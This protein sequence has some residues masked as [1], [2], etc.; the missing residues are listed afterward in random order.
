MNHIIIF[1]KN[2]INCLVCQCCV[3]QDTFNY[4]IGCPLYN[5]LSQQLLQNLSFLVISLFDLDFGR[6]DLLFRKTKR[7]MSTYTYL[8]FEPNAY[9]CTPITTLQNH[10]L[11]TYSH[12]RFS[13]LYGTCHSLAFY[14]LC[15]ESLRV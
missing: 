1:S 10:C 14:R 15:I 7:L 4:I 3:I 6:K 2:T 9:R 13:N 12:I 5:A 8:I 11:D